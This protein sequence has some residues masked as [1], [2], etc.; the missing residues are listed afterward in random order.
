MTLLTSEPVPSTDDRADLRDICSRP[1]LPMRDH[2]RARIVLALLE[3]AHP[4][5]TRHCT[6]AHASWLNSIEQIL[7]Y[8]TRAALQHRSV[9]DVAQLQHVRNSVK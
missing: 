1:S 8:L 9:T 6:P 3:C 7:G 5:F 4:R 2:R